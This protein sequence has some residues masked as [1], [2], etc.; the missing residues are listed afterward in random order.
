M[1]AIGLGNGL[2][3]S[4]YSVEAV[5]D[6]GTSYLV[7]PQDFIDALADQA[8][9]LGLN[10]AI[11]PSDSLYY[12]DCSAQ[13]SLPD[14]I[15]YFD[16]ISLSIPAASYVYTFNGLCFLAISS[17]DFEP[18]VILGDV[19]LV[20]YYTLYDF[21][22]HRVGLAKAAPLKHLPV[23]VIPLI[24]VAV[25]VVIFLGIYLYNRKKS[26]G[27]KSTGGY[28]QITAQS[29]GVAIGGSGKRRV[30]SLNEDNEEREKEG[31]TQEL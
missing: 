3:I 14:L 31:K 15:F 17:V 18:S 26:S 24:I 30:Y 6:T 16:N 10:C 13:E 1:P 22:N 21:D 11:N 25:L 28:T 29:T 5:F 2:N 4:T 27:T 8:N 20:D 19:F 12:C 23:W 7:F 9:K